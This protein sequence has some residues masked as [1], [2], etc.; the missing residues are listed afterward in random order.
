[1]STSH[2]VVSICMLPQS[3]DATPEINLEEEEAI[4]NIDNGDTDAN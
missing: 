2:R 1:M 3:L 4:Q